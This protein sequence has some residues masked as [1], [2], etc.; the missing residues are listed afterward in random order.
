MIR[1]TSH[2]PAPSRPEFIETSGDLFLDLV[3]HDFDAIRFVTGQ[4]IS[5]VSATAHARFDAFASYRSHDDFGV[6]TGTLDLSGGA[7]AAFTATRHNPAGYDIRMEVFGSEGSIVV[8]FD[9]RTPLSSVE[10]GVEPS[11]EPPYHDF[12]DRFRGAYRAEMFA[13]VDVALGRASNPC[14][15]AEARSAFVAAL[16]A[17]KSARED[18]R[19]ELSEVG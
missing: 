7:L 19:V 16:A 8:G 1:A 14:T 3:I 18:R 11:S 10:P 9:G 2:D 13:F 5:A 17:S 12:L 4:E 6:S 15:P